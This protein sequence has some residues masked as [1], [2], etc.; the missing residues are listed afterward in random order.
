MFHLKIRITQISL[1]VTL[2]SASKTIL[3]HILF[4]ILNNLE[5]LFISYF[6]LSR[7]FNNL[8]FV[9]LEG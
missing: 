5:I 2:T 8:E 9:Y 4:R 6:Y 7:I 1:F 3:F